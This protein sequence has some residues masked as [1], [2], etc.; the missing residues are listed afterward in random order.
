MIRDSSRLIIN[1]L[2]FFCLGPTTAEITKPEAL[3]EGII[4]AINHYIKI[5][6][7]EMNTLPI[8]NRINSKISNLN[9]LNMAIGEIK[10]LFKDMRICMCCHVPDKRMKL[11]MP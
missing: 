8:C 1:A 9:D 2:S 4:W 5:D 6:W 3:T 10:K 7:I 11:P